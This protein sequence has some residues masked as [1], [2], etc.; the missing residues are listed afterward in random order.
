MNCQNVTIV[1]ASCLDRKIELRNVSLF[2]REH[3]FPREAITTCTTIVF[4]FKNDDFFE[5]G[6]EN[7][8]PTIL[9]NSV[10]ARFE[11]TRPRE[12]KY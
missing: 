3:N 11:K 8:R 12:K 1:S 7:F 4:N 5:K 10:N 9:F 6:N 2:T